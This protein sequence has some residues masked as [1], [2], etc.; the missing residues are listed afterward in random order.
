VVLNPSVVVEVLSDSTE[1]YDRGLNWDGYRRLPSLSDYL[2]VSQR[3]SSIEH[4]RRE[5]DG[6]WRYTVAGA[7]ERIT[8]SSGAELDVTSIYSG[9]F[10]FGGD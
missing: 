2:L 7:G 1:Q 6:S 9:V 10:E 5:P 8:L 4:Y 3:E